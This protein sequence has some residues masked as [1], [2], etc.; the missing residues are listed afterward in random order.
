MCQ[1]FSYGFY[2]LLVTSEMTILLLSVLFDFSPLYSS[3]HC[4]FLPTFPGSFYRLGLLWFFNQYRFVLG[5]MSTF[6]L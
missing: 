6:L 3:L 4:R 2:S 1:I 5:L